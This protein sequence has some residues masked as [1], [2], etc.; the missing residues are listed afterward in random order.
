MIAFSDERKITMS[1]LYTG[2]TFEFITEFNEFNDDYG[3]VL[4]R[5]NLETTLDGQLCLG[6]VNIVRGTVKYLA[7]NATV[8]RINTSM[9]VY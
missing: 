3:E 2:D 9:R 6:Y 8:R 4:L 1:Q 5:V 7:E